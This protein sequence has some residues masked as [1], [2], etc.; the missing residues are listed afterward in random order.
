MGR[1]QHAFAS[2]S[3]RESETAEAL[4]AKTHELS[5]AKKEIKSVIPYVSL[6]QLTA[7]DRAIVSQVTQLEMT[8]QS[9][10]SHRMS[11][12]FVFPCSDRSNSSL[13][14][15]PKGGSPAGI[16]GSATTA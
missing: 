2:L 7:V 3:A 1:F 10:K 8:V 5:D 9:L 11:E 6:Y 4:K 13:R 16:A 15:P 12:F 14:V